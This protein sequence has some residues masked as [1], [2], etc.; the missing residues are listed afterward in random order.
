MK[1]KIEKP[2]ALNHIET[3]VEAADAV[4]V[5]RGD[6]AVEMDF[7]AVPIAQKTITGNCEAA[8]K[9]CI[10]ATE[11]LESMI[12]SPTP[13]RAEVSARRPANSAEM[14]C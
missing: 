11:M 2:Q 7:P 8:G 3:I 10:I 4:M 6:L 13:T 9:P 1:F 14:A 5:A 12:Q